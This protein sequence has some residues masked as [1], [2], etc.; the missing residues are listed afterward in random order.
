MAP[1]LELRQVQKGKSGRIHLAVPGS[2]GAS[3]RTLCN[4][5]FEAGTY[6]EV[7]EEAD[8]QLCLKR[9]GNKAL[10]S[11]AFFEG[12]MG[13]QLLEMSLEQAKEGRT[14]RQAERAASRADPQTGHVR[15]EADDR[16]RAGEPG[17]PADTAGGADLQP[18]GE[19]DERPRRAARAKPRLSVVPEPERPPQLGNLATA[20]MQQVSDNVYRSPAGV[21]IRGRKRGKDWEVAEVVFDGAIQV[22]HDSG[23]RAQLKI[24][25]VVVEVSALAGAVRAAYRVEGN[26]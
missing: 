7:D 15:G 9:R 11:S 22:K 26:S 10:V 18:P 4:K 14:R 1:N 21:V 8:C 12:E 13:S 6:Q 3:V 17:D 23:G 20:G 5:L 2:A 16:H 24:G 25:D 19:T